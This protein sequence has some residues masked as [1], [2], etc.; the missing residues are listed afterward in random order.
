MQEIREQTGVRLDCGKQR[1]IK[2]SQI[3]QRRQKLKTRENEVS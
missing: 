3:Q 2:T 1:G